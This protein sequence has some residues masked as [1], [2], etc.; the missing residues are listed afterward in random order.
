[1]SSVIRIK[2]FD[3]YAWQWLTLHIQG[4][5]TNK[6]YEFKLNIKSYITTV[7]IFQSSM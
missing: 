6:Y 5:K 3:G 1:M 7:L 2:Y 4:Q